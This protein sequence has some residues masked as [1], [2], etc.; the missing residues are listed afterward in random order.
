[1]TDVKAEHQVSARSITDSTAD[2][3]G[4]HGISTTFNPGLKFY[5]AF[6]S[7]AVLILMVALDATTLSVALPVCYVRV[8]RH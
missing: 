5:L 7:F 8:P 1:M 3:E 4:D 2:A 6:M